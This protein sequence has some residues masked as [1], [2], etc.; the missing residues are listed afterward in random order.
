M[1]QRSISVWLAVGSASAVSCLCYVL[2]G[3]LG[4]SAIAGEAEL[5]VLS[6]AFYP[7]SFLV[8][9]YPLPLLVWSMAHTLKR[10]E[11]R[12]ESLLIITCA[13]ASSMS[14]IVI[15]AIAMTLP[16]LPIGI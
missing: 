5:P 10:P 3:E 1:I 6:A 7:P 2:A 8:Y 9:L 4:R 13:L 12:D 14:F 11:D 16:K 15:F